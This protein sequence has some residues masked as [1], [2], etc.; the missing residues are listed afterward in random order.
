[1]QHA[2]KNYIHNVSRTREICMAFTIVK[3]HAIREERKPIG[4]EERRR[5]KDDVGPVLFDNDTF[6]QV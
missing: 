1:M 5:L 4:N 6:Q 2:K 3:P